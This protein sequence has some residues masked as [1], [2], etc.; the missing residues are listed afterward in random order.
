MNIKHPTKD[1]KVRSVLETIADNYVDLHLCNGEWMG[2][3]EAHTQCIRRINL[4]ILFGAV[5]KSHV[6]MDYYK[7]TD[8]EGMKEMMEYLLEHIFNKIE[9]RVEEQE[10]GSVVDHYE[11]AVGDAMIH[12]VNENY[13]C[14]NY[15]VVPF[16]LV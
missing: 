16:E 4:L 8:A 7:C 1:K 12:M 9:D 5:Y 13:S 14:M 3:G 2:S 11:A 10:E 15:E 6:T